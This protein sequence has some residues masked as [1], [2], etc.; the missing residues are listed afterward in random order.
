VSSAIASCERLRDDALDVLEDPRELDLR[1][2]VLLV[3]LVLLRLEPPDFEDEER[4][5][6]RFFAVGMAS[7]PCDW[8]GG[9]V[10]IRIAREE[11]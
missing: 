6:E 4:V 9:H 7:T 3:L 10:R 8:N 1:A 11:S 2:P 5:V